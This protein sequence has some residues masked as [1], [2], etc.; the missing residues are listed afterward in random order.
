[1]GEDNDNK[2][3]RDAAARALGIEP[4][5]IAWSLVAEP[6]GD[7][8]LPEH[9]PATTPD[10]ITDVAPLTDSE[11]QALAPLLPRERCQGNV[12]S[13]RDFLD[14]LLQVMARRGRWNARDCPARISEAVRRR[15][16][17]WAQAGAFE[18]LEKMLCDLDVAPQTKRL[19]AG[20]ARR[21]RQLRQ[22]RFV[23]CCSRLRTSA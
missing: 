4:E 5:L 13:N 10:L 17:R 23:A 15:F 18:S 7:D 14:A 22:T 6:T 16:S 19:L 3:V 20:A 21:A 12:M 1:V 9:A 8:R 11:W 2:T